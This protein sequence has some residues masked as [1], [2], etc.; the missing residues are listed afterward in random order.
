MPHHLDDPVGLGQMD[1][2][3]A[4]GLPD[5]TDGIESHPAHPVADHPCQ[6]SREPEQN[7]RTAPV[8][9]DLVRTEGGPDLT[10]SRGTA[11]LGEQGRTAGPDHSVPAG[12]GRG[13]QN[14]GATR[15]FIAEKLLDPGMGRR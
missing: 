11:E 13:F 7:L 5:E 10:H 8:H 9:I 12:G 4:W 3:G 6:Q 1:T 15:F 2:A 14:T